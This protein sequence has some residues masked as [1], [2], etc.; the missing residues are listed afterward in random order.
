MIFVCAAGVIVTTVC[1]LLIVSSGRGTAVNPDPQIGT[2]AV[3]A[4][5]VVVALNFLAGIIVHLVAPEHQR[6]GAMEDAKQV[7]FMSS[8]SAI[9]QRAGEMAPHIAQLTADHWETIVTQELLGA[10]PSQPPDL[11]PLPQARE[12]NIPIPIKK[13]RL[14]ATVVLEESAPPNK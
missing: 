5:C 11:L 13:K 1:D 10:I 7:I 6:H 9:R 12:E 4:T 2:I 14:P 8:M 3:W